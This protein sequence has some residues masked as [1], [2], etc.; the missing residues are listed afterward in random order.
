[1]KMRKKCINLRL[2]HRLD[3]FEEVKLIVNN[4][5]LLIFDENFEKSLK[6]FVK[7]CEIE[8]SNLSRL[9]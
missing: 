8:K 2:S 9:T 3:E 4:L 1:M 7:M 5:V 6:W